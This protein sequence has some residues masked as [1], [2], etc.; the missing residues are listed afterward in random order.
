MGSGGRKTDS[1]PQ[2][3]SLLRGE[4]LERPTPITRDVAALRSVF[5]FLLC[6]AGFSGKSLS[7]G[8]G[9]GALDRPGRPPLAVR[10]SP[11]T[12]D[13]EGPN[14]SCQLNPA[15]KAVISAGSLIAKQL[16]TAQHGFWRIEPILVCPLIRQV[17]VVTPE[18]STLLLHPLHCAS[19]GAIQSSW[20]FSKISTTP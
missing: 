4:A 18:L 2:G 8:S 9:R 14:K 15:G 1:C 11:L 5:L 17:R 16:A 10:A 3:K 7:L 13:I 12:R 6:H 19:C 20:K